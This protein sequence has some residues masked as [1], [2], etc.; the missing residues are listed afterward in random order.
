MKWLLLLAAL[1][2][3]ALGLQITAHVDSKLAKREAL[4]GIVVLH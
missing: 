1:L 3:L 4:L 2:G